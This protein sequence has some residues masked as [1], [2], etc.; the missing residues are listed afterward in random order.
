MRIK[1]ILSSRVRRPSLALSALA[2]IVMI[3]AALAPKAQT[4]QAAD[5]FITLSGPDITV[6]LH[7]TDGEVATPKFVFTVANGE[8][9]TAKVQFKNSPGAQPCEQYFPTQPY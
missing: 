7:R 3:I 5:G 4:A 8:T 1:S 2:L 6:T 9:A